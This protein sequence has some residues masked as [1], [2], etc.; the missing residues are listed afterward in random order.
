LVELLIPNRRSR[1]LQRLN[2]FRKKRVEENNL[3]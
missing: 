1:L 2:I 3:D